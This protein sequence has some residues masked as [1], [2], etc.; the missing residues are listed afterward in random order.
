MGGLFSGLARFLLGVAVGAAAGAAVS[1]L[2]APSSGDDLRRR[3]QER[4]AAAR[5]AGEQAERETVTA[6]QAEY[7]RRVAPQG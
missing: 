2:L 6:L 7:R 3:L 5:A 4:L 1:Y